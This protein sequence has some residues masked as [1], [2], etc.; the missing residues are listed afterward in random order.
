M[1]RSTVCFFFIGILLAAPGCL[2]EK[3]RI[4]LLSRGVWDNPGG[5][6]PGTGI[7]GDGE[8]LHDRGSTQ[9]VRGTNPGVLF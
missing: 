6:L 9:R 5:Q 1:C 7:R 3:Q 2:V 8:N 4:K